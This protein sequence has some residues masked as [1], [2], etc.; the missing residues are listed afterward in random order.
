MF[1]SFALLACAAFLPGSAAFAEEDIEL[2]NLYPLSQEYFQLSDRIYFTQDNK[3]YFEVVKGPFEEGPA[4]CIG[5]GFGFQDGTSTIEGIC[6]FGEG[7]HTFTMSWKLGIQGSANTWEISG[8]TG[9]YDGMTG[10]GIATTGAEIMYRAMPLRKTH[11]IG[12]VTMPPS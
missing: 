6:I 3:G 8:G 9:R 12:T 1:R 10:S 5:G 4:R 2:N 11:I 7:D